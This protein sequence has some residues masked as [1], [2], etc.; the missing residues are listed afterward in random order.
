[1]AQSET[2]RPPVLVTVGCPACG[3]DVVSPSLSQ[4][5]ILDRHFRYCSWEPE[6]EAPR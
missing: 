4:S 6:G 3:L 5:E 1:M 2:R